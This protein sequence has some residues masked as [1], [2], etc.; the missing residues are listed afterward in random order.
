V[1]IPAPPSL[2]SPDTLLAGQALHQLLTAPDQPVPAGIR[3]PPTRTDKFPRERFIANV[4]ELTAAAGLSSFTPGFWT[5]ARQEAFR[6]L[7]PPDGLPA[8]TLLARYTTWDIPRTRYTGHA[9]AAAATP[10]IQYQGWEDVIAAQLYTASFA[11]TYDSPGVSRAVLRDL[12]WSLLRYAQLAP[13][14]GELR[15]ALTHLHHVDSAWAIVTATPRTALAAAPAGSRLWS[16][17]RW[18]TESTQPA[19][20]STTPRSLRYQGWAL[21][22]LGEHCYHH[23]PLHGGSLPDQ[24]NLPGAVRGQFLRT[25]VPS[26]WRPGPP[27]WRA[28]P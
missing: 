1:R 23:R 24:A 11:Q 4:G 10:W 9:V 27:P 8:V 12:A 7:P 17:R 13:D 16:P 6:R 26:C 14:V 28:A 18:I 21:A 2:P 5:T 20:L 15:W 22:A 19:A 25:P 3:T